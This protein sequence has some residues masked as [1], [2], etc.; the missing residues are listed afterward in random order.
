LLDTDSDED[1]DEELDEEGEGVGGDGAAK[2]AAKGTASRRI[3]KPTR[4]PASEEEDAPRP[5]DLQTLRL[6]LWTDVK[7]P[8]ESAGCQSIA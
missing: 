6:F 1:D 2:N 3:G 8:D 7:V 4:R 5:R